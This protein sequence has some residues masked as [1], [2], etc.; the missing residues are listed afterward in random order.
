M[1]EED[2]ED[3]I[4]INVGNLDSQD[5]SRDLIQSQPSNA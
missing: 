1:T 3:K 2:E 5:T 4:N